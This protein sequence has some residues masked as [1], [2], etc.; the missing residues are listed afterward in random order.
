M[1]TISGISQLPTSFRAYLIEFAAVIGT[2]I[3]LVLH[4]VHWAQMAKLRKSLT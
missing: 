1:T 2:L 4:V 3:S